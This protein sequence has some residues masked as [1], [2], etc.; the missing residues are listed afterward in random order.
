MRG[1]LLA[2]LA[3]QLAL[4]AS[5]VVTLVDPTRRVWPPP[6]RASWQFYF[7][8]VGTSLHLGGTF[9][10]GVLGW[11]SLELPVWLRLVGGALLAVGLP[12]ALL[13]SRALSGGATLGLGGDLVRGGLYRF[14]RNPQ[15]VGSLAVLAGWALLAASSWALAPCIG[16]AAWYALAPFAEEPWLH[17]RYGAEYEAYTREVPRFLGFRRRGPPTGAAPRAARSRRRR[18][19][20]PEIIRTERLRLR[21]FEPADGPAVLA[22]S[23][24][25]DWAEYQRTTPSTAEEAERVVAELRLRDWESR[26]VW[27]IT[28]SERVV[29]LVSLEL[30]SEHRDAR[31]GYGIHRDHRGLGLAGEATRAVLAEAFAVHPQLARVTAHT[32][33]RN[34]S[35]RRLLEKLGFA[36]EETVRVEAKGKLVDGAVYGLLRSRWRPPTGS[37]RGRRVRRSRRT[38]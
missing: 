3:V 33:A 23:R 2:T 32:D 6:V 24:D 20:L 30:G 18:G 7:T 26:P 1:L 14:S 37:P 4:A 34:R 35:S 11:G 27:A 15:Y 36:H 16:A 22:Y 28:R 31:L 9:L 25:P 19:G 38:P 10:L 5:L 8:W 29:G 12:A 13:G 21:P 17:A